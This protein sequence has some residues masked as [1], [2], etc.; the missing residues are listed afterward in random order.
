MNM[1]NILLIILV[2]AGI[3]ALSCTKNTIVPPYTPPV[4]NNFTVTSMRHTKDTVNTG[5]TIYLMVS[6][7]MY[8]TLSVYTYLTIKSNA[9]GSPVYSYGSSAS[10]IKVNR[11]LETT[12][13]ADT[14]HWNA[15]IPL[16]GFTATPNSTLNISGT[17]IYQLS[18]SSEGGGVAQAA[19]LG[20]INKSVYVQ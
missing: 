5:D 17:F 10:P 20:I 12:N 2:I 16:A 18:L 13:A 19:D 15:V 7:T 3:L 8:D 4:T 14:N 9:S 1:K 6:G 11:Q